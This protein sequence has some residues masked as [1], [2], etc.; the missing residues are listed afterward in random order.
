L[1]RKPF[2]FKPHS[3]TIKASLKPHVSSKA[4]HISTS[5]PVRLQKTIY[6][7]PPSFKMGPITITVISI[8]FVLG[9]GFPAL[10][11][12]FCA[13]GQATAITLGGV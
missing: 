5:R 10:W 2:T 4:L 12:Y 3:R 8:L 9:F 7:R 13:R 6:E 1:N 11:V